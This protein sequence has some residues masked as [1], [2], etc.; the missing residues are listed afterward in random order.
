MDMT[1]CSVCGK[2]F[3]ASSE[4]VCPACHKL[5]EIVYGKARAFL[6][7]NAKLKLNAHEL[8]REIGED[9]RLINI[10]M[11][12][13]RF[14]N[15]DG[16]PED[17]SARKKQKLLAEIEKSLSSPAQKNTGVTTYGNDRHGVGRD[18]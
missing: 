15:G 4:T 1:T 9:E 11:M 6:R 3:G 2:I 14:E 13:G 18:R 8:A 7:D 16:E 5:L 10:L 17:I 12:E